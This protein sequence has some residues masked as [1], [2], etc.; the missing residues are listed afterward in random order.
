MKAM[1]NNEKYKTI[2]IKK[3]IYENLRRLG[4]FGDSMSSIIERLI[5]FFEQ[6]KQKK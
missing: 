6:N 4:L 3:E 2:R 5:K 1:N